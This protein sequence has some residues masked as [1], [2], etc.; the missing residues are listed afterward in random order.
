MRRSRRKTNTRRRINTK[1]I[2]RKKNSLRRSKR[3]SKKNIRKKINTKKRN[4]KSRIRS[5][6]RV[7]KRNTKRIRRKRRVMKGG[8]PATG[9]SLEDPPSIE[10]QSIRKDPSFVF[11]EPTDP[12]SSLDSTSQYDSSSVADALFEP[13]P[14]AA[15]FKRV[16]VSMTINTDIVMRYLEGLLNGAS[17]Y[18]HTSYP[19]CHL[20]P[21]KRNLAEM[22]EVQGETCNQLDIYRIDD[23][24]I[25]VNVSKIAIV[26]EHIDTNFNYMMKSAE[27]AFPEL[28]RRR[29]GG[30]NSTNSTVAVPQGDEDIGEALLY[31]AETLGIEVFFV[32]ILAWMVEQTLEWLR[33][34]IPRVIRMLAYPINL[35]ISRKEDHA[36]VEVKIPRELMI[37]LEQAQSPKEEQQL[38]LEVMMR[39][40]EYLN[41]VEIND[42]LLN[43]PEKRMI[44]IRNFRA[45]EHNIREKRES[46]E[47]ISRTES[48]PNSPLLDPSQYENPLYHVVVEDVE[49]GED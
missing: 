26:E 30:P 5:R 16:S 49:E 33:W 17:H 1:R 20:N 10:G 7:N 44:F 34:Q 32:I 15:Q 13:E 37:Q 36:R 23:D 22:F 41:S 38:A 40:S 29:G 31:W 28:L 39:L 6:N 14:Q 21:S 4:T 27:R 25:G 45:T 47:E 11:E 9:D 48:D 35:I 2:L 12:D 8:A 18:S 42:E 46:L 24:T 43:T 3:Y 19:N